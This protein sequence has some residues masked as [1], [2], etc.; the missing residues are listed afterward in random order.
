MTW[1]SE[2][3]RHHGLWTGLAAVFLGGLALN[4]T[5]CVYPM[6]PVT[7]AFFSSQSTGGRRRTFWL[8]CCYVVGLSCSYAVLGF[9]AASTGALLG[10]W[11]QQPLVLISIALIV[12][13]LALSMFGV[14]ELRPPAALMQRLGSASAGLW[15]AVAM[16]L[17]V[18]VVAAPCIGP[19][20]L[21]LMLFVSQSANPAMGFLLFFVLGLGMGLPYLLLGMAA[22]RVSHL[23]K[24]GMWMVWVKRVFGVMLVALTLFILKPLLP[25]WMKPQAVSS[26]AWAPYTDAA[27]TRAK[28]EQRVAIVDVYADWC[29][30]C[31]E[32]DHV[33]FRHPDVVR[34]LSEVTTLR[35]D[36]TRGVSP[37]AEGLVERFHIFG[38]PTVLM[39]DRTGTE[40]SDLRLAGFVPPEEFLKLLE[41]LKD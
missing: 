34:A 5:P 7:V 14:Y 28:Q 2:F 32:M 8:A 39:F 27:L 19:F 9:L 25:A 38:V 13:A 36:V 40:R 23:P 31:V 37:E 24:A 22:H 18:G 17:V 35:I 30:P 10:S 15:G 29:L 12:F 6:I 4:L 21:G 41:Q 11:L 1:L 16:G 26:V 33:T 3:I 20:V